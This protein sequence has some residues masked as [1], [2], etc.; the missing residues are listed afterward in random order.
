MIAGWFGLRRGRSPGGRFLL[1]ALVLAS[2][3]SLGSWLTVDGH[4]LFSLPWL[5]L[6][7]RP[8]FTDLVPSR[9]TVYAALAA[10]VIVA[11]WADADTPGPRVRVGACAL[12]VLAILPNVSLGQWARRPAVPAL[13]TSGLTRAC[14]TR[15]ENVLALP[16]GPRGD[17]ML[18][19][20]DA[21]FWFRMAGGYIAPYPP[22]AYTRPPSI[23][24]IAADDLPPKVTVASLRL[25]V[26]RERVGAVVL[27]A[28]REPFWRPLLARLA[29][30]QSLGGVLLY[31]LEPG[32]PPGPG[33]A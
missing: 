16:Y 6:A 32:P 3:A 13:L 26:R 9:L 23:Q 4:R 22:P 33:C 25:F 27:D 30:P 24:R 12:A 2:I 19:Q 21:G 1:A 7:Y 15:G 18:W 5:H 11:L 8:L 29:R 28:R 17:S 14:L 31:R 10:S 20:V